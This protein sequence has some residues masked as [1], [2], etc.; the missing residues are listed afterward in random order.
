MFLLNFLGLRQFRLNLG[1]M[2]NKFFITS[3]LEVKLEIGLNYLI[4]NFFIFLDLHTTS[5]D[6]PM[7]NFVGLSSPAQPYSL[8]EKWQSQE[9]KW[10]TCWTTLAGTR[11]YVPHKSKH[12]VLFVPNNF[13]NFLNWLQ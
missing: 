1:C 4:L 13:Q 10:F 2:F 6:K 11:K 8:A 3:E 5:H 12:D 7:G 9:E